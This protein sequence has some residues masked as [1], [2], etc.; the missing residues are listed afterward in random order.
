MFIVKVS[1]GLYDGQT[2]LSDGW[3][4]FQARPNQLSRVL[5]LV[6][7]KFDDLADAQDF[8]VSRFD[9]VQ[10]GAYGVGASLVIDEV[11]GDI[12]YEQY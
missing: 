12:K 11:D 9:L 5:G 10:S 6:T 2:I 1:G 8:I 3:I 7:A 4:S